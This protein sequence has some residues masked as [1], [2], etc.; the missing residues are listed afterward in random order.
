MW[1]VTFTLHLDGGEEA[2]EQEIRDFVYENLDS[3]AISVTGIRVIK[4]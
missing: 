3:S 4:K 1:E 2:T